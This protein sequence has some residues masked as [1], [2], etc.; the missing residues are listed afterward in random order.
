[1][2]IERWLKVERAM[3]QKKQEREQ[4]R[5]EVMAILD[6]LEWALSRLREILGGC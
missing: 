5:K 4:Q 2:T 6:V 3:H 1:M